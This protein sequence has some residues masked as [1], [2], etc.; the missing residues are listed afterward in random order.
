MT[1]DLLQG[2][3][4]VEL[5]L[6]AF[7]PAAGAGMHPAPAP[8]LGSSGRRE[9]TRVLVSADERTGVKLEALLVGSG[10]EVRVA[11]GRLAAPSAVD[12]WPDFLVLDL[13]RDG[14][15]RTTYVTAR[16]A[17][18]GIP[19]NFNTLLPL[20][21]AWAICRAFGRPLLVPVVWLILQLPQLTQ[22]MRHLVLAKVLGLPVLAVAKGYRYVSQG[23]LEELV[24]RK[25]LLES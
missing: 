12:W 8:A 11:R 23:E 16:A 22:L 15:R 14:R 13:F 24:E 21:A 10:Y 7:A 1:Y 5:S 9:P 4:V 17:M 2:V 25:N 3:R 19:L 20:P 6:Y 18:Y